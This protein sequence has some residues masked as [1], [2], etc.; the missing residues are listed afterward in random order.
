ML[1]KSLKLKV[2]FWDHRIRNKV[3]RL[4][5]VFKHR[6][7]LLFIHSLAADNSPQA[8]K[9]K[10]C[11]KKFDFLRSKKNL[12]KKPKHQL[13]STHLTDSCDGISIPIVCCRAGAC[14]GLFSPLGSTFPD[15]WNI[16]SA[17]RIKT[18]I[19]LK[20]NWTQKIQFKLSTSAL[21]SHFNWHSGQIKWQIL[22]VDFADLI[23]L[24]H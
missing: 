7:Q 18:Q 10:T 6:W 9:K 22:V 8:P 1:T 12:R 15:V 24:W 5:D 20:L 4:G 23:T 3:H 14:V 21:N 11:I 13:F 16:F 17:S 19:E 2:W